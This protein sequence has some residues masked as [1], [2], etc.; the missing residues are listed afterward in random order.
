M[1]K[2]FRALLLA[3]GFGTRLQ[4]L[5]LHTPKCL[6][7]IGGEP[8]LGIWLRKL[9]KSWLQCSTHKH[10]LPSKSGTR[11]SKS[12]AKPNDEHP[13]HSRTSVAGDSRN[14]YS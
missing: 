1:K 4:P 3:A 10:S 7:K 13:D 5:T 9:E 11:V 12:L 2:T 8:L 14:T 6:V